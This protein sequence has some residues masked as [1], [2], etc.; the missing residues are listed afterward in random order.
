M[1]KIKCLNCNHEQEVLKE[2]IFQDI[3]GKFMVCEK[4]DSSFDI[5]IEE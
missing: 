4:C 5:E 2:K 1:K 3:K